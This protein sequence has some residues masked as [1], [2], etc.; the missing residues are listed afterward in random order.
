MIVGIGT[1][2]VEIERISKAVERFGERFA[3]RI[4]DPDELSQY[5]SSSQ[6]TRLL[7]RRFAAKEAAAKA[8]K[9]GF[10]DGISWQDLGVAHDAAGA[11][12]LVL[13]GRAAELANALGVR[14]THLSIS[15]E[16]RYALA[17]VVLEN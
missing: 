16:Q 4:L 2:V 6:P 8:L 3:R 9:R 11:P 12:T 5:A 15:D 13:H 7:A 10:S 14:A 17:F 1:D